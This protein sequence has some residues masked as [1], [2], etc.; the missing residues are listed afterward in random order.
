MINDEKRSE[1]AQKLRELDMSAPSAAN[2]RKALRVFIGLA[3]RKPRL[4]GRA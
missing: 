2:T 3:R 4:E 1:V